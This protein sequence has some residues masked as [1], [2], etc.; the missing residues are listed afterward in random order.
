M[1]PTNPTASSTPV[2]W[3]GGGLDTRGPSFPEWVGGRPRPPSPREAASRL[4][5]AGRRPGGGGGRQ[6]ARK[7]PG[8]AGAGRR[9]RR[10]PAGS[11]DKAPA[12]AFV[13][14]SDGVCSNYLWP[15][16]IWA[17]GGARSARGRGPR[18]LAGCY[19]PWPSPIAVPCFKFAASNLSLHTYGE[20]GMSGF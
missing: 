16:A 6:R 7:G 17:G 8:V 9:G 20:N 1:P 19:G 15:A 4:V 2:C 3:I 14:F 11:G 13:P 12:A 10:L 18:W 5:R